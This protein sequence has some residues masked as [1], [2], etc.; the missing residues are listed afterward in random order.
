MCYGRLGELQN[1]KTNLE[2]AT[3]RFEE[4]GDR[5][6]ATSGHHYL[7]VVCKD[8]GDISTAVIELDAAVR[9]WQQL[10]NQSRLASCL[11][12]YGN[13]YYETGNYD[14]AIELLGRS[15]QIC[16]DSNITRV[17][18]YVLASMA[19][20][21]SAEGHISDPVAY[22]EAAV[23]IASELDDSHLLSYSNGEWARAKY[24]Q[25]DTAGATRLIEEAL[26]HTRTLG[27][28]R[29][30]SSQL[31]IKAEILIKSSRLEEAEM[32]LLEAAKISERND[33][34]WEHAAAVVLLGSVHF[35]Q[36][37]FDEAK[38]SL[39]AAAELSLRLG[40]CGFISRLG[41]QLD[42][43]LAFA[44]RDDVLATRF[45]SALFELRS[46]TPVSPLEVPVDSSNEPTMPVI[47]A[48]ALGRTEVYAD[49]ELVT[50][51]R[52]RSAKAKEMVFFLASNP[53]PVTKE[54]LIEELWPL[55]LPR[56]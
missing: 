32:N 50:S 43:T 45:E 14:L 24:L 13:L 48:F 52:W 47:V 41:S 44:C 23:K 20:V 4:T 15:K 17:E 8:S 46:R 10:G 28:Q 34:V 3:R 40:H 11:N 33:C 25:G 42:E 51:S 53:G 22:Y 18:G 54:C 1:A 38:T 21:L 19:R 36:R 55:T 26:N 7:G 37:K 2:L 49:G 35:R 39:A 9:G 12:S 31:I 5:A 27:E 29:Q 16:E 30:E 6:R 56:S